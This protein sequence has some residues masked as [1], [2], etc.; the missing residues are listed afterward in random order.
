MIYRMTLAEYSDKIKPYGT[1]KAHEELCGLLADAGFDLNREW[2]KELDQR[3]GDYVFV[4]KD[5]KPKIKIKKKKK[6][7]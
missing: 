5:L 6:V 7:K 2:H 3:T 4:Q 1:P